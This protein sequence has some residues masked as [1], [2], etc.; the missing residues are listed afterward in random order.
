MDID[1]RASFEQ[2]IT[3]GFNLFA[4]AGFSVA[5]S[6]EIGPLPIGEGLTSQLKNHFPEVLR[7]DLELPEI[8][9]LLNSTEP[10]RLEELIRRWYTVSHFDERYLALTKLPIRNIYTT[11]VDNLF[12]RIYHESDTYY[13]NDL[14]TEGAALSQRHAVNLGQLHGSVLDDAR[15]MVFGPLEIATASMNDQDRWRLLRQHISSHPTL[16][17]GYALRD[18]GTLQMLRR[19]PT[20]HEIQGECWIQ[21]R[22]DNLASGFAEYYR[23]LGFRIIVADTEEMLDYFQGLE[24]SA[25]IIST[26]P[27][28]NIPS[29]SQ[30]PIRPIEDFF[31]GAAPT[32]SDIYSGSLA[33]TSRFF[34]IEDRIAGRQ[35]TVIAGIPGAGKTTLLMQLAIKVKFSGPKI[36]LNGITGSEASLLVRNIGTGEALIFLD[37][38]VNDIDALEQ[39]SRLPNT[40]IVAADRDYALGSVA[41]IVDRLGM[42]IIGITGISQ[43][44]EVRLWQSIPE[45]L[46]AAKHRQQPTMTHGA[47]TS[48]FEF[49]QANVRGKP[50]GVRLTEH[51]HELWSSDIHQAEALVLTSY[52]HYCNVPASLDLLIAYFGD[53]ID[54]YRAIYD[55]M[56]GVGE[57]LLEY[58][59]QHSTEEQDYYIGRSR[60]AAEVVVYGIARHILKHV[61][62]RFH[63]RVSPA[64]IPAYFAFK[65]RGY[66]ARIFARAF[67]NTEEGIDLYD[68]IADRLEDAQ[69]RGYVA[70]QKALYLNQNGRHE[71]AFREIDRVRGA[72]YRKNWTIENSY[73]RILFDTNFDRIS[74]SDEGEEALDQCKRAIR[75]LSRAYE[76]DARKFQHAI[77]FAQLSLKL[78]NNIGD[79]DVRQFLER[80]DDLMTQLQESEPW[81][82]AP[83]Y[84]Q[85][86]VR[87][88]KRSIAWAP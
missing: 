33:R 56:E 29:S 32:W 37:D 20:S 66:D 74:S 12:Q 51:V 26:S 68:A 44:D 69:A 47:A 38:A 27:L 83:K 78:A 19:S 36:F 18:V 41:H 6:S 43:A 88:L 82:E 17:W 86:D 76:K 8:Y 39:L 62:S 81:L 13:L 50:L 7:Y 24:V 11:N 46:R 49:V 10:D 67:R 15:P 70:Q 3:G 75:G 48:I 57:L 63:Q 34:D 35:N 22:P 21:M 85:R 53:A 84:L 80:A 45:R 59:G 40:V 23:A 5:A 54:D 77:A 16:F 25:P 72:L 55:L 52:L 30:V 2:A 64:R 58:A 14:Y 42:D 61:L 31:S 28:E 4:G 65:R 87:A 79:N 71:A 1:N 73:Y 60:I 9:A